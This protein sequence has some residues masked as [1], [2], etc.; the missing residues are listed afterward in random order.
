MISAAYTMYNAAFAN[1]FV[2][3]LFFVYQFMLFMKTRNVTLCWVTGLFFAA[4]YAVSVFV[5]A[6]SIQAI[7]LLLVFELAGILYMLLW[8]RWKIMAK[9][10]NIITNNRE[11]YEK[12]NML[13]FSP[14]VL[15]K[16][17][18]KIQLDKI[19]KNI[20]K[21]SKILEYEIV[22]EYILVKKI[23]PINFNIYVSKNSRFSSQK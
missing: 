8:K 21:K 4:L 19:V 18:K 22:G 5:K 13:N 16:N 11:I 20:N 23:N 9:K 6:I 3:I 2:A 10:K 14:E 17:V 12:F 1:W 7:F 15:L